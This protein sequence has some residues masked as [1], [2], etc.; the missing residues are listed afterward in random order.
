MRQKGILNF[1]PRE[2]FFLRKK[3]L[4]NENV[5]NCFKTFVDFIFKN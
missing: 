5:H 4:F 2:Y 1:L 3:I